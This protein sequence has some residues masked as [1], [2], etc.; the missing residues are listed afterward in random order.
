MSVVINKQFGYQP[1]TLV[2]RL[3]RDI[4]RTIAR[5]F[6]GSNGET[7]ERSL[8]TDSEANNKSVSKYVIDWTPPVDVR[9]TKDA[10]VLTADLPGVNPQD[11]EVTTEN[12]VL[13]IRG[14]R[15]DAQSQGAQ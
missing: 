8:S 11:I 5:E 3:H 2:N 1:W 15:N 4:E 10:F 7:S 13:T 14:V 6:G 9:E 12:G